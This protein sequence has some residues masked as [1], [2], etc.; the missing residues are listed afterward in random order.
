MKLGLMDMRDT[1]VQQMKWCYD[2]PGWFANLSDA[3]DDLTF[4]DAVKSS[5]EDPHTIWDTLNHLIYWNDRNLQKFKDPSITLPKVIQDNEQTFKQKELE[6]T[7]ENWIS[8][9]E[10]AH[11]VFSH[12]ISVVEEATEERLNSHLSDSDDRI[13][14]EV[15]AHIIIHNAYHIGQIVLIRKLHGIWENKY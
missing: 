4:E 6:K 9:I 5:S 13:A 15:I 3:L 14:S 2:T 7:E 10:K 1:L 12:W 11:Q 8:T